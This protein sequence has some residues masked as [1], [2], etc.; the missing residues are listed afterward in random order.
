MPKRLFKSISL[1]N[2]SLHTEFFEVNWNRVSVS[3]RSQVSVCSGR[4]VSVSEWRQ[5]SVSEWRQVSVSEWRQV[6]VSCWNQVSVS[7]LGQVSDCAWKAA[8]MKKSLRDFF[9][10]LGRSRRRARIPD[11]LNKL[12]KKN[13]DFSNKL[14][15]TNP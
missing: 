10:A 11:F 3:E 14:S 8:F 5:V 15:K 12:L 4:Q 1:K 9:A 6:S 7:E 2:S 13:R